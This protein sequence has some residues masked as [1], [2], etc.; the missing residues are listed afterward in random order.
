MAASDGRLMTEFCIPGKV[1]TRNEGA[2]G[3]TLLR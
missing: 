3:A 1:S 2:P